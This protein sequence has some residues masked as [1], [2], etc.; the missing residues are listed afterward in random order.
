MTDLLL[1]LALLAAG[2]LGLSAIAIFVV[3]MEARRGTLVPED[4][5][6][7]G[8]A[9]A[10]PFGRRVEDDLSVVGGA[11]EARDATLDPLGR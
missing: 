1:Y 11:A 9:P 7:F 5:R 3:A 2:I 10:G 6:V 8:V 4:A